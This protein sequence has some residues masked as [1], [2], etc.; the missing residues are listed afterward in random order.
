MTIQMNE[1]IIDKLNDVV[2]LLC[3]KILFTFLY[4]I[5]D[6]NSA[7]FKNFNLILKCFF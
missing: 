1:C 7:I 2:F 6:Y 5:I 3:I 4:F